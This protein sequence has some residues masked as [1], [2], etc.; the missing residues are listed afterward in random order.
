MRKLLK[1]TLLLIGP[2]ELVALVMFIACV[3]VWGVT[4]RTYF[5]CG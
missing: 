4:L 2:H 5:S 3:M 1:E